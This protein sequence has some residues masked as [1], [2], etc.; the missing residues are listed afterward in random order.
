[1]IFLIVYSRIHH[2]Y[3]VG[4]RQRKLSF[5]NGTYCAVDILVHPPNLSCQKIKP[6]D[7]VVIFFGGSGWIVNSHYA[8]ACGPLSPAARTMGDLIAVA[9]YHKPHP[10]NKK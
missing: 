3:L 8:Y 10:Q 7:W 9:E 6:P 4:C 5:S 1:M 2:A